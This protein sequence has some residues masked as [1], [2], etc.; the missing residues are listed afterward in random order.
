MLQFNQAK[1]LKPHIE[2]NREKRRFAENEFEEDFYKL[3]SNSAYGKTC[4]RKRNRI[5]V[6]ITQ[7]L[8]LAICN[9]FHGIKTIDDKLVSIATKNRKVLWDKPTIV[10]STILNLSNGLMYNFHFNIMKPNFGWKLL[11]S[12]KDSLLYEIVS[13]DLFEDIAKSVELNKHFDFSNYA[14]E[15]ILFDKILKKG[16]LKLKDQ[17]GAKLIKEFVCLKPKMT[18]S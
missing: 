18:L 1:W 12:D 8:D 10:G 5:K 13:E 2:L 9:N 4:E 14:E 16:T 15:H 3:L 6:Q 17:M 7:L 11:Y